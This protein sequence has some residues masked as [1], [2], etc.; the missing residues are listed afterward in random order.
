MISKHASDPE[1]DDFDLA[2]LRK[3]CGF[4]FVGNYE[5]GPVIRRADSQDYFQ[6]R[7]KR[8]SKYESRSNMRFIGI[9]KVFPSISVCF[10][11][12]PDNSLLRA[13]EEL[14]R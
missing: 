10:V 8:T 2:F 14:R 13:I 5:G 12:Y 9:K 11:D 7:F 4:L 6:K 1:L 3:P